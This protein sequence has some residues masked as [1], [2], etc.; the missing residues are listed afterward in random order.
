MRAR[1]DQF[2]CLLTIMGTF[3]AGIRARR[4]NSHCANDL[5]RAGR[6]NVRHD[7]HS[8]GFL[9]GDKPDI[10]KHEKRPWVTIIQLRDRQSTRILTVG[11]GHKGDLRPIER[12]EI[13]NRASSADKGIPWIQGSYSVLIGPQSF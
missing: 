10:F 8:R 1:I 9:L 2:V 4:R 3:Q 7:L 13:P 12:D 6:Q 11:A 5:K